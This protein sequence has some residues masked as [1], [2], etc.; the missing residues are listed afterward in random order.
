MTK[1][2]TSASLEQ[3]I[4]TALADPRVTSTDLMELI[5]EAELAVTAAEE[6][7]RAE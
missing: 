3:R 4:S 5:D 7:A 6:T 1:K 2:A